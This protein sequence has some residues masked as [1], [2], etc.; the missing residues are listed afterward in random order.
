VQFPTSRPLQLCSY[1]L[2]FARYND[3]FRSPTEYCRKVWCWKTVEW[4]GYS[5]RWK[6]SWRICLLVST[7]YTNV[8][9]TEQTDRRTDAAWQHRPR[10]C[11]ASR[12]KNYYIINARIISDSVIQVSLPACVVSEPV[13]FLAFINS[14]RRGFTAEN[15]DFLVVILSARLL[16][17]DLGIGSVSVCLSVRS[18]H[19]NNV[20]TNGS[21]G[22]TP[23]L[24]PNFV[25]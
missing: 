21:S 24:R 11:I 13:A 15:L 20:K 5:R 18:S 6:R 12:S 14:C 3:L 8:T 23:F 19:V 10:V 17:R 2:S 4:C 9:D 22:G 1:H 7:Q 25:P 16:Q